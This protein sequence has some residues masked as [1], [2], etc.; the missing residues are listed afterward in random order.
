MIW[1]KEYP[2]PEHL[3]VRWVKRRFSD[4][5]IKGGEFGAVCKPRQSSHICVDRD[6]KEIAKAKFLITVSGREAVLEYS[7]PRVRRYNERH[8]IEL[9]KLRL[10]FANPSRTLVD[11]VIWQEPNGEEIRRAAKTSWDAVEESPDLLNNLAE[12]EKKYETLRRKE[13]GV[14]RRRLFGGRSEEKCGICG[15][16]YPVELLVVAHIKKRSKCS[17][18]EKRDI[19]NVIP[20]CK[21]GCDDLFERRYVFVRNGKVT[22]S[23]RLPLTEPVRSYVKRIRNH[24]CRYWN[25]HSARYFRCHSE[26][27]KR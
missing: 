24:R 15:S 12:L 17:D 22:T 14:L 26:W 27:A 5:V 21:F 13:Q 4:D 1:L 18:S 7:H 10:L 11:E 8:K 2:R 23:P 9:G 25:K 6:T 19:A 20:M 16:A 3:Q